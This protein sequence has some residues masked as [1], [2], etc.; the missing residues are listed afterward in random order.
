MVHTDTEALP[1]SKHSFTVLESNRIL[2][3]EQHAE[4]FDQ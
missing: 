3:P 1:H 4:N 2:H